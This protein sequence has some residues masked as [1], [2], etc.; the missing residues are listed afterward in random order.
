MTAGATDPDVLVGASEAAHRM[1]FE[2]RE[3]EHGFIV[4]HILADV[5]LSEPLAAGD[6]DVDCGERVHDIDRPERP[7]VDFECLD[8][9]GCSIAIAMVQRVGLDDMLFW[10]LPF[11]ELLD[12]GGWDNVWAMRLAGMQFHSRLSGEYVGD[13]RCDPF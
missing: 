6:R 1:A 9:L 8:M 11:E 10:L 7:A 5:H 13:A 12:P 3:D 4:E 2:M